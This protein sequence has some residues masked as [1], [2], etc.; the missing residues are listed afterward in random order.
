[1]EN[2]ERFYEHYLKCGNAYEPCLADLDSTCS[3]V[4]YSGKRVYPKN[5]SEQIKGLDG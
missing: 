5:H 4:P 2:K 3:D 1:M